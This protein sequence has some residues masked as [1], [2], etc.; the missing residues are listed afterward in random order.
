MLL[1]P[2]CMSLCLCW[3]C[4][5]LS[6][7]GSSEPVISSLTAFPS[8][9]GDGVTQMPPTDTLPLTILF[10]SCEASGSIPSSVAGLACLCCFCFLLPIHTMPLLHNPCWHGPNSS[11]R[12]VPVSSAWMPL[13]WACVGLLGFIR[14]ACPC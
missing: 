6:D 1:V 4:C 9:L 2:L 5:K 11:I 7:N 14:C 13:I 10:P 12:S 8:W 3:L